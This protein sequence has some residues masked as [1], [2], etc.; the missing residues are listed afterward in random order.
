[1]ARTATGHLAKA[2]LR[3]G[4]F[5]A[6]KALPGGQPELGTGEAA[7]SEKLP[8]N[9]SK[10]MKKATYHHYGEA[11]L[12]TIDNAIAQVSSALSKP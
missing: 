12:N 4:L 10:A 9:S 5:C 2:A 1:M 11:K 7:P 3:G 6:L 8:I